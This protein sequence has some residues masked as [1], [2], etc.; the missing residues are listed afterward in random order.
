[1]KTGYENNSFIEGFREVAVGDLNFQ[2]WKNSMRFF[3]KYCLC[4]NFFRLEFSRQ[5]FL[6]CPV[7]TLQR[8]KLFIRNK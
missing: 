7:P 2:V 5:T 4:L 8:L 1:M 3:N 6:L